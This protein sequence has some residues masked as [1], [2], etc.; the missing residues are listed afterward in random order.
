[1]RRLKH[2]IDRLLRDEAGQG[3]VE[4][5]L[6]FALISFA[7]AAGMVSLASHMNTAFSAIGSI[8]G[9]TI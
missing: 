2:V 5:V 4:Y 7:A 8:F 9:T 1:M 6:I 3:L